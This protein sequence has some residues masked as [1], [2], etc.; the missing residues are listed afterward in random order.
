[1]VVP[2]PRYLSIIIVI[3]D[4]LQLNRCWWSNCVVIE[5][6]HLKKGYFIEPTIIADVDT[7]MQIWSEEVFGP[8]LSVKTFRTEDE[9][10][11]LANDT[12]WDIS[13]DT[14][15]NKV[16]LECLYLD[17]IIIVVVVSNF[18]LFY[19]YGLGGAVL[20]SDLERCERISKVLKIC[21][22]R[23]I[24]WSGASIL[25]FCSFPSSWLHTCYV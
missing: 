8:V 10:I 23:Y 25:V 2:A 17:G 3:S 12:R 11:E 22:S 21:N 9:A 7:S 4:C 19:S 14:L 5:W 16:T 1:M 15:Y 24:P 6:Q 20:S 18:L 13:L